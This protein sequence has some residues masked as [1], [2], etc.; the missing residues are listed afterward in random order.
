MS[1]Y[2]VKIYDYTDEQN[3]LLF[4]VARFYPKDFRQQRP[5]PEHPGQWLW[6]LGDTRRVLYRLPKVIAERGMIILTE[7][8]KDADTAEKLGFVATT[9]PMGAGKWRDEYTDSLKGCDTVAILRD[10]DEPGLKDAQQKAAALYGHVTHVK[11]VTLPDLPEKGDLSDWVSTDKNYPEWSRK[12]I[13]IIHDTPDYV[14]EPEPTT[15]DLPFEPDPPAQKTSNGKPL[16]KKTLQDVLSAFRGLEQTAKGWKA[17]CPAHDDKK[18]SLSIAEDGEKVLVK[19]HA[20]CQFAEIV[21]AAGLEE[22]DFFLKDAPQ[23]VRQSSQYIFVQFWYEVIHNAGKENEWTELKI[24]YRL[25]LHFLQKNGFGLYYHDK[26]V[27]I[28]RMHDN[29]VSTTIE[30][31]KMNLTVKQFT[32]DF[33]RSIK[34][35][36]VLEVM[37]R[38]HST[39][40]C[41]SFLTSMTPL[42]L[43][44]YRDGKSYSCLFFKNGF[45]EIRKKSV[46]F[47]P[48]SQLRGCVWETHILTRDYRGQ[49]HA[50]PLIEIED[51]LK[52][53]VFAKFL[54][55][56]SVEQRD[57][58][59]INNYYAFMYAYAYLL[60]SYKDSANARAVICVDNDAGMEA[61]GRRGKSL[62]CE[63]M[64]RLRRMSVEDGKTLKLDS[65]FLFQI[66]DLDSQILM[67]DDVR[68][69]FDFSQLY[70]TITGDMAIEKKNQAR[71]IVSFEDSPKMLLTTNHA[72]LGNGDSHKG[73]WYILPFTRYFNLKH[74]PLDEFGCRLFVEWD[75]LEW[76]RFY[77]FSADSLKYYFGYAKPVTADL[78]TYNEAKLKSEVYSELLEYFDEYITPNGTP[79]KVDKKIFFKDFKNL[80]PIYSER[81]ESWFTKRL[82]QYCEHKNIVI[83]PGQKDGRAFEYTKEGHRRQILEFVN[84]ENLTKSN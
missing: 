2:I 44:F 20:G 66:L 61:N 25:F 68:E 48:Y 56:V 75:E 39:F 24:D 82:K 11:I 62:F 35:H 15:D 76:Q 40:F 23:P 41:D 28:V 3:A 54:A 17:Q 60:H 33:I 57:D 69:K 32:L 70:P 13:N 67:I 51:G 27:A 45:L 42:D 12:L 47:K 26:Q 78:S 50:D 36:D 43:H 55:K 21:R 79:Y 29:I 64:K 14:P 9:A 5:D 83:N 19:C 52:H 80:Y 65:N 30:K 77:D 37:L 74:T 72:V 63:G 49:Y 4:R 31:G 6:G 73:R 16:Q 59:T 34:K 46:T 18:A 1:S 84:A 7:G 22:R 53:S 58:R 8:E 10:N 71:F 38:R 81:T